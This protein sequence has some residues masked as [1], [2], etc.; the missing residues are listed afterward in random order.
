MQT[1]YFGTMAA[2][3]YRSLIV[4]GRQNIHAYAG[5]GVLFSTDRQ[6]QHFAIYSNVEISG[7]FVRPGLMAKYAEGAG[8]NKSLRLDAIAEFEIGKAGLK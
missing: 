2:N 7:D 1:A 6:T 3:A 5:L 8:W 4:V